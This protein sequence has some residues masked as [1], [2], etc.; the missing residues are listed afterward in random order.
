MI[1]QRS[2]DVAARA[3]R[4]YEDSLRLRLES[5]HLNSFVAIE[6][7]SGDYFIADNLSDAIQGIRQKY[8]ERLAYAMRVGH[9]AAI[10]IGV[11]SA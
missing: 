1:T 7:D 3:K 8:P 5:T 9:P 10:H 4:L 11:L 2:Q 6:P